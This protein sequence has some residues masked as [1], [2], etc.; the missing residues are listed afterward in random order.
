M[1]YK[2][3]DE[4]IEH[5]IAQ[6]NANFAIEGMPL[7]EEDKEILRLKA[8]GLITMDDVIKTA[9]DKANRGK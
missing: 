3:E 5:Q 8:K 9:L 4:K 1:K 2:N 6:V 7:T